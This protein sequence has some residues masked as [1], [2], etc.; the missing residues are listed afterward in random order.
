VVTGATSMLQAGQELVVDGARARC[1]VVKLLGGGSQGEVY[2]ADLNGSP[3]ALKWYFPSWATV[4]QRRALRELVARRAPSAA[5]LWPL[6]VVTLPGLDTYG[7][8][9]PL[10]EDRFHPMSELMRREVEADFRS[11]TT[12]GFHLAH[13]VLALHAQGLCYRDISFGNVALD[14]GTG[15]VMIADNDNVAVDGAGLGGVLGTPRFM[16]PEVVRGEAMP[17][18]HT[19]L[20]SLAVLL[21][22]LFVMHHPLEGERERVDEPLDLSAMASLYGE[23]AVFIFDPDDETNRP[24][25][26]AHENALVFWPLYPDFLRRLFTRAFTTGLRDPVGGRVREGEWRQAMIA[27]RDLIVSCSHCGAQNFAD[28]GG[29]PHFSMPAAPQPA[30]THCWSC[31]QPIAVPL[32]ITVGRSVVMLNNDTRMHAH[33]TDPARRYFTTVVAEVCAHPNDPNVLG[34]RNLSGDTWRCV[35]K[36]SSAHEVGPGHAIRLAPGST[37]DFGETRGRVG[38]GVTGGGTMAEIEAADSS[39]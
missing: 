14:P 11:L 9:M 28:P 37:I 5:F 19:D 24:L 39:A 10:L 29:G 7:Y 18:T 31:R 15:D 13:N 30:T 33:H 20:W 8:V 23:N 21:F 27:L 22:Y 35:I 36:G 26:A 34:L 2:E 3:V 16:A 25:P 17:G 4:G 6:A 1:R 38:P 12:T 32:H